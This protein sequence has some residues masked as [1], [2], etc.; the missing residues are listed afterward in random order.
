[1]PVCQIEVYR[2]FIRVIPGKYLINAPF[3][4]LILILVSFFKTP[5]S[6]SNAEAPIRSKAEKSPRSYC[7]QNTIATP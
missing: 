5:K 6:A 4:P 2:Q 3:N 7:S 1:M